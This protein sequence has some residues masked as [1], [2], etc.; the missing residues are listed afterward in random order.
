VKGPASWWYD[1]GGSELAEKPFWR[2]AEQWGGHWS[3]SVDAGVT[4][5][6]LTGLG[7]GTHQRLCLWS[8]CGRARAGCLVPTLA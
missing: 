4:D 8:L 7:A 5:E 6:L 3:L 1:S 2:T